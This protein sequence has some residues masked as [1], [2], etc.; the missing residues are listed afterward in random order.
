MATSLQEQHSYTQTAE[1]LFAIHSTADWIVMRYTGIQARQPQVT[2]CEKLGDT[3]HVHNQREMHTELPKSLTNFAKEW[4]RVVQKE[5]WTM[6]A[7]GSYACEFSLDIE[8][9]PGDAN[10]KMLIQNTSAGCTND[11]E[12]TVGCNIPFFGAKLEKFILGE[13]MKSINAEHKWIKDFLNKQ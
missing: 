4:N 10:G 2:K 1:Q 5:A 7:D 3:Y 11:I 13:C 6:Q 12:L 9:L 8:G